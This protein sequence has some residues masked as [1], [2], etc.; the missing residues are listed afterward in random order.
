MDKHKITF[1]NS[2]RKVKIEKDVKHAIE[3]SVAAV[4]ED[5]GFPFNAMIEVT[6][7]SNDRIRRYNKKYRQIDAP[8]DV[9]SFPMCD[10]DDEGNIVG[11]SLDEDGL[12]LG[13]IVISAQRAMEQ[14]QEYGHSFLR[15]ITYLAVHSALHLLGY[16]H[17]DEKK[18]K[19]MRKKEEEILKNKGF[20]R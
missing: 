4:L 5:R 14:A 19:I 2:Q 13:D 12:F 10:F 15:E 3:E 7:V 16:D 18:R 17:E 1:Y 20:V 11:L 6:F 9:L 8:T